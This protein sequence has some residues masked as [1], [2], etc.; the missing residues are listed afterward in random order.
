MAG[1]AVMPECPMADH[2]VALVLTF[3]EAG[4]LFETANLGLY[5]RE[6]LGMTPSNKAVEAMKKIARG[7]GFETK[8]D[9]A[10]VLLLPPP[11]ED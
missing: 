6:E 3:A 10:I 7:M 1:V 8:M 11:E 2:A 4:A 5:R 9:G